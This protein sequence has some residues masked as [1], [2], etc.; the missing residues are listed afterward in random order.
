MWQNE[1]MS[2]EEKVQA[3]QNLKHQ[4]EINFISLGQLLSEMKRFKVNVARGYKTFGEFV[5]AE[6]NIATGQAN[7]LISTYDLY[8]DKLGKDEKTVQDIGMEKLTMIKPFVKQAKYIE[9]EEW[10]TKAQ[11]MPTAQLREELNEVRARKALLRRTM[12]DVLT[13]QFIESMVTYFNCSRKELN[14]KLALYFQDMSMDEVRDVIRDRQRKFEDDQLRAQ[15][16]AQE[17]TAE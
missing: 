8:I 6:F 13:D 5:E 4:M 3:T 14:F 17:D 10:I 1:E 15:E 9:A 2:I 12:K 11:E 16:K 7:K